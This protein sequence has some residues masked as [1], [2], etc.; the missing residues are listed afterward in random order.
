MFHNG[1]IE[2]NHTRPSEVSGLEDYIPSEWFGP[3]LD[4]DFSKQRNNVNLL[5]QLQFNFCLLERFD[6]NEKDKSRCS[7][8][9]KFY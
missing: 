5:K 2:V 8:N 4:G 3:N 1:N 7:S 9:G 6:C